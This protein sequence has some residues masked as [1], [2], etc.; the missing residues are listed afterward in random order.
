MGRMII[1]L[2]VLQGLLSDFHLPCHYLWFLFVYIYVFRSLLDYGFVYSGKLGQLV[3]VLSEVS[4]S[5][6]T[7]S[8][9]KVQTLSWI[10]YI[11]MWLWWVSIISWNSFCFCFIYTVPML[12]ENRNCTRSPHFGVHLEA[13]LKQERKKKIRWNVKCDLQWKITIKRDKKKNKIKVIYKTIRSLI[14][15]LQ[16]SLNIR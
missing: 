13:K 2:C 7:F 1:Y 6:L 5:P 11:V 8:A 3:D 15:L 12:Y 4:P 16:K 10:V 14:P 9:M